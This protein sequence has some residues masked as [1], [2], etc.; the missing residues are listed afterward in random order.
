MVVD[1]TYSS[2]AHFIAGQ[3][4][5]RQATVFGIPV[6]ILTVA[7]SLGAGTFAVLG[8]DAAV[9]ALLAFASAV[10]VALEKHFDPS[11]KADAHS[12]K[13]DRYLTLRNEARLFQSTRIRSGDVQGV[14][15]QEFRLLRFRYDQL[16]ES[17]PRQL[18]DGAYDEARRQIR[19]KQAGY[20]DDPLWI[21]APDDLA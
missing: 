19:D 2:R 5:R 12:L 11:R 14:L 13:G 20:E 15:E 17:P 10:M 4:L 6:V 1:A 9:V 16:R 3:W 18:P 8:L 21:A 7:T